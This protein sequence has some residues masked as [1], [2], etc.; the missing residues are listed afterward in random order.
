[1]CCRDVKFN[2]ISFIVPIYGI[3]CNIVILGIINKEKIRYKCQ[4][5][6][7]NEEIDELVDE[8]YNNNNSTIIIMSSFSIALYI[9]VLILL[10][11][12][13]FMRS[14]SVNLYPTTV[15]IPPSSIQPVPVYPKV[16]PS[17]YGTNVVYQNMYVI[18]QGSYGIP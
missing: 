6:G 3:I 18:P 16:I 12:L 5:E 7:F 13:K 15:V 8:Q 4:L 11:C 1:M 9:V 10:L 2:S 17:P 14:K